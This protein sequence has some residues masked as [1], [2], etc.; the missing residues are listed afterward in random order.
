MLGKLSLTDYLIKASNVLAD[1]VH[2]LDTYLTWPGIHEQIIS[3]FQRE[4]LMANQA[5]LLE[6]QPGAQNFD[7]ASGLVSFFVHSK[8]KELAMLYRLYS[9]IKDGLKPIADVYKSFLIKQ[10]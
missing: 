3:E 7:N 8:E 1:E 4:M 9:P 5:E 6:I 10:G 2:R